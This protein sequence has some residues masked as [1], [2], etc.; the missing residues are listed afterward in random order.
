MSTASDI[1]KLDDERQKVAD[2]KEA[3]RETVRELGVQ[4]REIADQIARLEQQH[5][6]EQALEALR[7]RGGVEGA[8]AARGIAA[9]MPDPE[10]AAPF[11]ELAQELL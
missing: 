8:M 11:E 6:D 2:K 10:R 4:E 7:D 9:T 1:K 5:G 3:A